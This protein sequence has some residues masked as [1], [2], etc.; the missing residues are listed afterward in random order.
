MFGRWCNETKVRKEKADS[1][2]DIY[3]KKEREETEAELGKEL[4][5]GSV[6]F[7]S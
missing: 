7:L 1:W 3:K 5:H 4:L 6:L 2:M